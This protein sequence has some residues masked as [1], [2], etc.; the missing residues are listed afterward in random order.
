MKV[1]ISVLL[2]VAIFGAVVALVKLIVAALGVIL[3]IIC[4]GALLSAS[5]Q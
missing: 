1:L 2:I 5:T 3:G 4:L